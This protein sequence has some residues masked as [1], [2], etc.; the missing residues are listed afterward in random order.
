MFNSY[1]TLIFFLIKGIRTKK[2][3]SFP[4]SIRLGLLEAEPNT[5]VQVQGIC[6]ECAF[7]RKKGG[8]K[9]RTRVGASKVGRQPGLA[10]IPLQESSLLFSCVCLPLAEG[11]GGVGGVD[12]ILQTRQVRVGLW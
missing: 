3:K 9:D 7:R 2:K 1:C 6:G 12:G 11:V 5:G 8:R 4:L 10:L